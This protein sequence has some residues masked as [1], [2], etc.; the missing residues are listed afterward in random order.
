MHPQPAPIAGVHPT[1]LT[2][3]DHALGDADA[4]FTL[5]EYGD[6]QCTYSA[7]AEPKVRHLVDTFGPQLRFVFRH[8]PHLELH[9]HSELAA[10]A[11]EAA[12]AQGKFWEMHRLLFGAPNHLSLVD[13]TKNAQSIGLDMTRFHAEMADRIYTQRVQEHRRAAK[14]SNLHTTPAFILNGKLIDTSGGLEK[15]EAALHA[16]KRPRA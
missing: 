4:R 10:E 12:A 1:G 3:D 9:P 2:A 14:L 6:Y 16:L 5:L 13:L 8:L 7:E 11:A 15:L